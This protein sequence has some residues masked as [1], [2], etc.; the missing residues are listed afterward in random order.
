MPSLLP[1]PETLDKISL[2][3]GL[4]KFFTSKRSLIGRSFSISSY[5]SQMKTRRIYIP[6]SAAYDRLNVYFLNRSMHQVNEACNKL[7]AT[8]E[9]HHSV[10][11]K[12]KVCG[13]TLNPW[14]KAVLSQAKRG[15]GMACSC[16]VHFYKLQRANYFLHMNRRFSFS[17]FF[18]CIFD[19]VLE[20]F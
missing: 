20:F 12:H 19:S 8:F 17:N 16:D 18:D 11:S 7:W 10:M 15:S 4:N 14:I 9:V 6:E 13:A 3:Y 1:Q 5:L 2:M